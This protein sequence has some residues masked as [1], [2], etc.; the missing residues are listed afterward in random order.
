MSALVEAIEL[1]GGGGGCPSL[2]NSVDPKLARVSVC[3]VIVPA[4][5]YQSPPTAEM[6]REFLLLEPT[7]CFDHKE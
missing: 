6:G 4:G 2:L 1:S 5:S 3:C 7:S